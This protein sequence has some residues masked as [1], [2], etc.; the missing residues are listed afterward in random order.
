MADSEC[1]GYDVTVAKL[2]VL[3]QDTLSLADF[4][5]ARLSTAGCCGMFL[6]CLRETRG[7][8]AVLLDP[9]DVVA[10]AT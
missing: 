4:R 9:R 2:R 3:Q 8:P 6:K 1:L 10:R 5:A 7:M